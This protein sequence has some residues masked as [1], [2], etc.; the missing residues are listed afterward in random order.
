M[1]QQD[2]Q[3]MQ[4]QEQLQAKEH[5]LVEMRLRAEKAEAGRDRLRDAM[6]RTSWPRAGHS[7]P[8]PG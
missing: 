7:V 5:D 6:V 2:D 8:E 3:L 4:L 1:A